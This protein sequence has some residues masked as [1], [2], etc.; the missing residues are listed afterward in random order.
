LIALSH[1]RAIALLH[2]RHSAIRPQFDSNSSAFLYGQKT[3]SRLN[4]SVANANF[5][6]SWRWLTSHQ[7]PINSGVGQKQKSLE[8][9]CTSYL[10][11]IPLYHSGRV[12]PLPG[13][14][15]RPLVAVKVPAEPRS[16]VKVQPELN[17]S[18]AIQLRAQNAEGLW[19]LQ[20]HA[21]IGELD[22]V[23]GIE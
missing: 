8:M 6:A 2:L 14:V 1:G 4:G 13:R 18:G 16:K 7:T 3:R 19:G 17:D 23:E 12:S 11:Q 9:F 20:T 5:P 10:Q 22:H 15:R 21:G